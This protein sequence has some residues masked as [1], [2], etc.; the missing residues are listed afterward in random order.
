MGVLYFHLLHLAAL[1]PTW[2][3]VPSNAGPWHPKKA[4]RLWLLC[5]LA[6]LPK[7]RAEQ[8]GNNAERWFLL[9]SVL[10]AV[11]GSPSTPLC[12]NVSPK[13]SGSGFFSYCVDS[14][15]LHGRCQSMGARPDEKT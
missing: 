1:L 14:A 10:S 9:E 12:T 2:E 6:V 13:S 3:A 15:L 11:W 8:P 4:T 5:H 7:S